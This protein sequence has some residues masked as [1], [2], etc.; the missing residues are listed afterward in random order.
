MREGVEQK[1]PSRRMI[2]NIYR[3]EETIMKS[4]R[5]FK[6][7]I[8]VVFAFSLLLVSS[9]QAGNLL[10]SREDLAPRTASERSIGLFD[11]VSA[12]LFGTW[13]D[14]R[15]VFAEDSQTPPPTLQGGCD[16]GWGLDPEGCPR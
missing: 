2:R 12:W 16:A 15:S 5:S 1:T 7:I 10:G 9:A 14:L 8:A 13:T 11:Q 3:D 4:K 6:S